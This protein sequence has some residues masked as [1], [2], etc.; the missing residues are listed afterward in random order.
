MT[1]IPLRG[2]IYMADLGHGEKPWLVISNNQRNRNLD[3]IM[4]A[5][6]TT[7]DRYRGLPTVV[8]L[9]SADP[10]VGFVLTDDLEQL[11]KDD[12]VRPCGAL[13]PRTLTAV[14]E[15]LKVALALP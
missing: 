11:Y 12:L 14:G 4:S 3:T 15:A 5:R 9:T 13:S 2:Q 8:P 10:L 1:V 6:I 7:T